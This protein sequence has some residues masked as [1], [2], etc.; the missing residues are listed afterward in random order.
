MSRD[1]TADETGKVALVPLAGAGTAVAGNAANQGTGLTK[2]QVRD[3][4]AGR[5]PSGASW[6]ASRGARSR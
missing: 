2:V 4:F 5:S 1:L 3:I 6:V